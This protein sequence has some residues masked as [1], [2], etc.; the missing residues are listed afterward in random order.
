MTTVNDADREAY[1]AFNMLPAILAAD[2]RAGKWDELTGLQII[3]RHREQA[4]L[5]AH[6]RAKENTNVRTGMAD[7]GASGAL[8]L[9]RDGLAVKPLGDSDGDDGA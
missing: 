5:A 7:P 4:I 8:G 3:A 6:T 9:G 2:V 1:L